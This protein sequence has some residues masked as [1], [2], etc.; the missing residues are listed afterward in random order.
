MMMTRS[1]VFVLLA[2]LS[3]LSAP[4]LVSAAHT[5]PVLLEAI[6]N[7]L[8]WFQEQGWNSLYEEGGFDCSRM[9]VFFWDYLRRAYGIDSDIVVSFEAGHAWLGIPT[10]EIGNTTIY[11]QYMVKGV[12]YYFLSS[13][14]PCFVGCESEAYYS[15]LVYNGSVYVF[16]DP[17][18]VVYYTCNGFYLSNDFRL[19]Y[20]DLVKIRTI[21]PD[22]TPT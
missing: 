15:D 11:P 7:D 2:F 14:S 12:S 10:S 9:S 20:P 6:D 5:S 19:T 4:S 17:L 21:L 13:T 22:Y 3:I 8:T 18:E 16:D 1:S